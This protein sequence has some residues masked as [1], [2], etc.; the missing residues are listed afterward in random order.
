MLNC[1]NTDVTCSYGEFYLKMQISSASCVLL[2]FA[3]SVTISQKSIIKLVNN[4]YEDILIAIRSDV[5][6]NYTLIENIK[7]YSAY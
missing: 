7:V 6:E 4:G 1:V 2:L 3:F 5:M